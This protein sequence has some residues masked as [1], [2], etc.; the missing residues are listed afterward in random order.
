VYCLVESTIR[1]FL[2]FPT[3]PTITIQRLHSPS[4]VHSTLCGLERSPPLS[5]KHD[6]DSSTLLSPLLSFS[7]PFLSLSL[8]SAICIN[9][10]T[11]IVMHRKKKLD[12][13]RQRKGNEGDREGNEKG[14]FVVGCVH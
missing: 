12:V 6:L 7:L 8:F 2:L 1:S 11:S 10:V 14:E 13:Q 5:V 3:P 4:L 9:A